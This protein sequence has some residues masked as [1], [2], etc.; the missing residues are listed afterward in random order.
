L[1]SVVWVIFLSECLFIRH[2]AMG[3]RIPD[4]MLRRTM[5]ASP[6]ISRGNPCLTGKSSV[7][8]AAVAFSVAASII[9]L[10]EADEGHCPSWFCG[11]D[12]FYFGTGILMSFKEMIPFIGTAT[13]E[14]WC[15]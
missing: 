7:S 13:L 4:L 8:T 10:H 6:L 3:D 14:L 11:F 9:G 12:Y 5:K 15:L 2:V 1:P